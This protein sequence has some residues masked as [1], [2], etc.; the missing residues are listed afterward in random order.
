MKKR[1]SRVARITVD[2]GSDTKL[3]LQRLES[4][5]NVAVE[6]FEIKKPIIYLKAI[7]RAVVKG[8]AAEAGKAEMTEDME[9]ETLSFLVRILTDIAVDMTEAA[10]L[11]MSRFFPATAYVGEAHI[12]EGT[13][14][15]TVR[16]YDYGNRLLLTDE[17]GN[18]KIEAGRL[19]VVQ[20]AY[21]N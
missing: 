15:V 14:L 7:T 19:N 12:K 21:M 20:S 16:Y 3:E 1:P 9:D 4:L 10:D 18:V 11:R 5:E 6:T 2:L 13:Y 8:L 17:R